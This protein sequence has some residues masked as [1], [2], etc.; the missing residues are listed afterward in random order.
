MIS[1][2]TTSSSPAAT[3]DISVV[4]PTFRRPRPLIEAV[5]SALSQDGVSIEVIVTDDSA[6]GSA[7]A[8]IAALGD[9]RVLYL[10]REVPSGGNPSRVRNEGA[11]HARGRFIHFL[12]D[13]D[14]VI[15]GAYRD[16]VRTFQARPDI[17]VV[18]GHVLPFGQDAVAVARENRVFA[19]AAR[20]ARLYERL[21]LPLLVVA[22]QLF[23]NGTV[24]VNSAC[25]VRREHFAKLG[26]YDEELCVVEDLEFYIRAI[27]SYGCTFLDRPIIGYRTGEPS[28]MNAAMAAGTPVPNAYRRIYQKYRADHGAAELFSMKLVGK[29]LLRWL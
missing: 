12:D 3:P 18:Y 6:E 7:R 5:R 29:A 8:P 28:L 25:V 2:T 22:N 27:R 21:G 9:P 11:R 20:R 14:R 26:G 24:L 19:R 1:R 23:S 15:P 10:Q 16:V 13:D 4:V 17:G